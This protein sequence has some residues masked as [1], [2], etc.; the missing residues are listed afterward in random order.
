ML[1]V[2][3]FLRGA[4]KCTNPAQNFSVYCQLGIE[5][6]VRDTPFSTDIRV[7]LQHWWTFQN[8]TA[9]NGEWISGDYYK[10]ETLNRHLRKI[11]QTFLDIMEVLHLMNHSEDINYLMIREQYDPSITAISKQKKQK[12]MK[13]FLEVLEELIAQKI[14]KKFAKNTLKTYYSRKH[15]IEKFLKA[16]KM[17]GIK[18]DK[19]KFNFIEE[20]ED[21]MR[22]QEDEKGEDL[23]CTNYRNKHITLIRQCLEYAVNKEYLEAMPIGKLGLEYDA[24]KAPHYLLPNQRQAIFD[25]KVKKLEVARDVAIFLMF[26][27]FSYVDYK[28]LK[29]EH[30]IGEGFKKTRHKSKVESLPVLWPEAKAI[31]EKYGSIENLP[32]LEDKDINEQLKWL[33]AVCGLDTESLGYELSTQDFRDTFCSM[34]ENEKMVE[35]RTL[36]AMMGHKT[37]KQLNTYSRMMPSRILHDLQKQKVNMEL[38]KIAV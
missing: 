11:E 31:I 17:D 20:F 13:S 23:F 6:Q 32:R 33:G 10:A 12:V 4:K 3:F 8:K 26:T 18:I 21:W 38:I 34:M 9:P 14:K 37:M 19:I 22:V 16:E 15:N 5:G 28:E 7:P 30:L 35:S 27:G 24:P 1:D 25:C 29:S 2:Q 36:M